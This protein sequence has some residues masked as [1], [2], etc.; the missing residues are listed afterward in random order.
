VLHSENFAC[1]FLPSIILFRL[2][3]PIYLNG[4][5]LCVDV[6]IFPAKFLF[7]IWINTSFSV[8][9][10]RGDEALPF[11]LCLSSMVY[12]ISKVLAIWLCGEL[13][14]DLDAS[15]NGV[16]PPPTPPPCFQVAKSDISTC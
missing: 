15:C 5:L 4:T 11:S 12:I 14:V 6:C 13:L 1:F 16:P 2:V 8:H 7:H 10:C 3:I 9:G